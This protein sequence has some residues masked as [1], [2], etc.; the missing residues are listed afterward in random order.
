MAQ[1]WERWGRVVAL[2]LT[3]LLAAVFA[4]L[5]GGERVSLNVGFTVLYQIPLVG[6]VFAV[7]LLGM[8]TMFLIGLRHDLRVR[9][10]LREHHRPTPPAAPHAWSPDPPPDPSP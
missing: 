9:R 6:L 7:F 4:F 3:T 8:L 5:N 2:T 1:W 10:A